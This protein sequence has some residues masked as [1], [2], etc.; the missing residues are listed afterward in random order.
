MT[1]IAFTPTFTHTPWVDSRDR[2]SAGG[3]NGFNIRF[4]KIRKDLETLS[5]VV[6]TI[7][8][9]IKASGAHV[10]VERKLSVAPAFSP[11]AG[12]TN[13]ELD[14]DG[15]AVRPG[16]AGSVR[17]IIA[18]TPPDGARLLK[19]RALGTNTGGGTLNIIL[20]RTKIAAVAE[21]QILARVGG[22]GTYDVTEPVQTDL[23]Q[24]DMTGYRY[25]VKAA[26]SG[27]ASG[28]TTI[29]SLQITYILD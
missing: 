17:G 9:V 3:P 26:F 1:N 23:G 25:A 4:D 13:W 16:S 21:Q 20:V 15:V 10:P 18:V 5:G 6:T 2:V 24:V 14:A 7:D 28:T 19:F 27:A 11:L 12:E 22:S 29:G 8:T